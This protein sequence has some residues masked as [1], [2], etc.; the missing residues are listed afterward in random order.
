MSVLFLCVANSARSQLA[1]GL[2]RARF[3][4]RIAVQ[5]AGSRPTRVN[6]YAIEVLREHG[7]DISAHSSKLVDDID[8]RG[9]ELVVTLCAEEVCPAFLGAKRRAHWPTP[10]PAGEGSRDEQLARFRAARDAIAARLDALEPALAVPAGTSIMPASDGDRAE[11]AALLAACALPID[12][13]DDGFP[14][15]FAIAR[16]AGE[17]VAVAGIEV[18]G[19]H[20]LLRS[21]AVAPARR[22][23]RL[24]T[25]VVADRLAW[26]RARHLASVSLLTTGADRY[27][28][29]FGFA[30]VARAALPAE[31]ARS[32]QLALPQCSTA[33]AMRL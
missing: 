23:H 26:A 16:L 20:G 4:E 30:A 29:R 21:V 7:I 22:E 9:I 8:P 6:P 24:A 18:W 13:L 11:L 28:A 2:A 15:G 33:V 5:S 19:D 3:G 14:S 25:A 1:E 32:T 10:D 31:L 12:G 17:L 27:F